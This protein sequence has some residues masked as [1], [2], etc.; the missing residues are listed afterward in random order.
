MSPSPQ[1]ARIDEQPRS[2]PHPLQERLDHVIEGALTAQRLV[3][4]VVVVL[5]DGRV[6]YRRAAGFADREAGQPMR[7]DTIFRL[8]S[9]TKPMVTFLA[10]RLVELG[11]LSLT[12]A[13]T[14]YLPDFRPRL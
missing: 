9:V 2:A 5:Q 1:P 11:S 4:T 7:A 8:S 14:R 3:G 10:L 6:T 12:D 13:V